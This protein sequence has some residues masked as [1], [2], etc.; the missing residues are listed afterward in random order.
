MHTSHITHY[1]PSTAKTFL[2]GYKRDISHLNT[3]KIKTARH[4]RTLYVATLAIGLLMSSLILTGCLSQPQPTTPPV[5]ETKADTEAV[6]IVPPETK[7]TNLEP[8]A[9]PKFDLQGHRGARGLRPENTLPAFEY[10]LDLGVT[11]LE[12]D[13]HFSQDDIVVVTHD[14]VIGK[15]CRLE[16]QTAPPRPSPQI[17]QLTRQELKQYRCDLNPNS[18]RFPN[19]SPE[20]MPLAQDDYTIPTLEELFQFVDAY[21]ASELKTEVQRQNAAE[22]RFNIET[23]RKPNQPELIGD[24]FDGKAPGLFEQQIIALVEQYD[25]VSR[26]TIQSFDHRSINVIPQLN[27]Q[28]ETVAL[29]SEAVEPA[30][31]TA[32]TSA[33]IWSPDYRALTA[34]KIKVAH[35]ADL[36]VIPWTVNDPN[37]ME[38][39]I[40]WGV[41]GLITDYPNIL[42]DILN[43]RGIEF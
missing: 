36:L 31:I 22:V 29:T 2:A 35:E 18:N 27:P 6:E 43:E 11:S 13:L 19:Q 12:L 24:D 28:V 7:E 34:A 32:K 1:A 25:L 17:R 14:G 8:E 21:A 41:D 33:K 9:A 15:N 10:A 23:K 30:N 42:A 39:L 40:D 38:N 3:I 16:G 37:T 26:V 20:S 4:V 5:P